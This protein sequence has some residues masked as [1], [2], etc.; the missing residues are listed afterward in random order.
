V[1]TDSKATLRENFE[2]NRK[3]I[4]N[5]QLPAMPKP[6]QI[7]P[8]QKWLG[9]SV[10]VLFMSGRTLEGE[11]SGLHRFAFEIRDSDGN[12]SVVLKHGVERMWQQMKT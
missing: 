4:A 10:V 12:I 6:G 2:R 3:A 7:D 11:L 8:L 5:S 9:R 1:I